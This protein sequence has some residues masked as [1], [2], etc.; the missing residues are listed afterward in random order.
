MADQENSATSGT[1]SEDAAVREAAETEVAATEANTE[2]TGDEPQSVEDL[3]QWARERLNSAR[4]E[5]N[6]ARKDASEYKSQKAE[7]Q[8]QVS[9]LTE[10]ANRVPELEA[11]LGKLRAV[12]RVGSIP[13][14]RVDDVAS[15]L[16]G[17]TTDEWD[18]DAQELAGLFGDSTQK[19]PE[20][21]P[22]LT[23]GA[24]NGSQALNGDPMERQMRRVLGI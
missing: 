15:R 8:N 1:E 23:Q 19:Q 14:D 7:L 13:L 21:K 12:L 3:P 22:D 17:T 11:E 2:T 20:R 4:N 5:K 10:A 16:K 9:E 18:A 6:R 24:G